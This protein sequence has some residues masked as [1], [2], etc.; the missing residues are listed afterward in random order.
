MTA[1]LPHPDANA[2][3]TAS[4]ASQASSESDQSVAAAASSTEDTIAPATPDEPGTG[5]AASPEPP[6]ASTLIPDS[7]PPPSPLPPPSDHPTTEL[8]ASDLPNSDLPNSD[9]P[10]T[11]DPPTDVTQVPAG[12]MEQ[13][14]P[15]TPIDPNA[16]IRIKTEQG[17]L[18]AILPPEPTDKEKTLGYSWTELVQQLQQRLIGDARSWAPG[19]NV[20]VM[21][22]DRLL[23][24]TQLQELA[25]VLTKAQLRLKRVYTT[26][27]QTA[28]AAATAG[29]SVEQT[30]PRLQ[31]TKPANG[32]NTPPMAEPLYLEMTLRSGAEIRHNGSVVVMGDLNPGSSIV[33]E[34][35]I[36]I[37]GRL[38]G[39]VHAGS[40]GNASAIV[41]ALKMEP[42]QIRIADFVARGPSN[43]PNQ[44]FP[45]VA[46]VTA[47]GKIS[48]A[49]AA[50]F[51]RPILK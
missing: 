21:A 4:T 44:I 40:A 39:V 14:D 35:D 15:P 13:S 36:L 27:R 42:A 3:P 9:I 51:S 8:V 24:S 26:R 41:M 50:D 5:A 17:K 47:Q 48:I 20:R 33:A 11:D 46:Y 43:P 6:S 45:E 34:G 38:R 18:W 30:I 49:S 16:Q 12:V 37:W 19:S 23:N 22:R 29:Y 7:P 25:E 28:V 1:D 10:D 32:E 31:V 2:E